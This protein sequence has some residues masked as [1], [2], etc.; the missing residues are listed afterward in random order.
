MLVSDDTSLVELHE[1][2]QISMG[3]EGY[4]LWTFSIN[5]RRYGYTYGGGLT[6]ED[7]E[8]TLADLDLRLRQRFLYNYDFGDYWQHEMRLEKI[9]KPVPKQPSPIC[10][11]G[12]RA[13]PPEDCGGP[14]AYQELL[15][16]ARSP[17]RDY[18]RQQDWEVLGRDFNPETFD[19][20]QVNVL[21]KEHAQ[22]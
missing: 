21:L 12:K 17:F 13:C 4:H 3:W 7:Y 10:I 15:H 5:G 8:T 11:R 18:E 22:L 2:I 14:W 19:R 1:I 16:L 9:V 6:R 20:R